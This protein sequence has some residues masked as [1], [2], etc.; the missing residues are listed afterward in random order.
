MYQP[1]PR[2]QEC[3]GSGEMSDENDK[4]TEELVPLTDEQLKKAAAD[5]LKD[6]EIKL[7]RLGD[8]LHELRQQ[9]EKLR[10]RLEAGQ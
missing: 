2:T 4:V 8:L 1:E 7:G 9:V 6:A 10:L 3:A 5:I